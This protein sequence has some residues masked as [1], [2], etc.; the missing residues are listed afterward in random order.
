MYISK[1]YVVLFIP[2]LHENFVFV[3]AILQVIFRKHTHGCFIDSN[4]TKLVS[5]FRQMSGGANSGQCHG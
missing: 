2:L 4:V 5:E 1:Y 3:K